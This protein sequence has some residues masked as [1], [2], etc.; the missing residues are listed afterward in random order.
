MFCGNSDKKKNQDSLM[1]INFKR[2][3]F[4]CNIIKGRHFCD[5][6]TEKK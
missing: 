4:I 3:A 5:Q 2:T 6:F 1:N